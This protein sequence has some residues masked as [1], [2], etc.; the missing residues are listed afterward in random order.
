MEHTT[1][2]TKRHV[3]HNSDRSNHCS[4]RRY[5]PPH[6][7]LG[8]SLILKAHRHPRDVDPLGV[9]S[10][11]RPQQRYKVLGCRRLWAERGKVEVDPPLQ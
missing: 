11:G 2:R 10:F 6:L 9:E 5:D 4:P 1:Y 7:E 8:H 3:T